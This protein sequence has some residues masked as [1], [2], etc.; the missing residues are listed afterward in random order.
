MKFKFRQFSK[1]IVIDQSKE[2]ET[3]ILEKDLSKEVDKIVS[4]VARWF[5]GCKC[6]L[7]VGRVEDVERDVLQIEVVSRFDLEE[8][9]RMEWELLGDVVKVV[10]SEKAMLVNVMVKV[11][12]VYGGVR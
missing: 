11:E 2:V 8:S 5:P 7:V 6:E 12:G 9:A 3:F 4:S 1:D 10:S